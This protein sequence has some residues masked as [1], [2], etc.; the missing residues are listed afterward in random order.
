M[1]EICMATFLWLGVY[2]IPPDPMNMKLE[3]VM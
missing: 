3:S 1:F 2:N